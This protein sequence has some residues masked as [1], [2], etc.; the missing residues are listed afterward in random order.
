MHPY[1]RGPRPKRV[2]PCPE[3][4]NPY[5]TLFHKTRFPKYGPAQVYVR[6]TMRDGAFT[7]LT[8]CLGEYF[9][10][11]ALYLIFLTY[12]AFHYVSHR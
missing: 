4:G 1:R 5:C 6:M 9:V 12:V 7:V 8:L 10:L 11:L 2:T 3:C